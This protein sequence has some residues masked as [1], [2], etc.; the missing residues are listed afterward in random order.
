MDEER[1]RALH[2]RGLR[3]RDIAWRM[4]LH[5]VV[6]RAQRRRLGLAPNKGD[7]AEGDEERKWLALQIVHGRDLDSMDAASR[8]HLV[9][10]F[11]EFL[12]GGWEPG[13]GDA[14]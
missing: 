7:A 10:Q 3:D 12:L 14:L 9:N 4:R 2:A 5:E 8:G 1:L 6:V 13:D 11:R